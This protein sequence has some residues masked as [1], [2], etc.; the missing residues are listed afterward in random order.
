MSDLDGV[1]GACQ[2]PDISRFIPFIPVPYGPEDGK[3]WLAAVERA[4]ADSDERTFGI[5][6][7]EN[8]PLRGVVTVRLREGGTVG[9]WL[10]PSARGRGLMT[11]A[12]RAVVQWA[13]EEHGIHRLF[14]TTH[15][16]NVASQ[17]V[18]EKAGF[19]RVGMTEHQPAFR[20]GT[21]T[22]MLFE[23]G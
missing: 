15:P 7:E 19:A 11:Q 21:T 14:L 9:Y 22:A 13:R 3:A 18:A 4:W 16:D 6:D 20:D 10:D 23:L 1:V 17:R 12:V 8:G 2:D 5:F